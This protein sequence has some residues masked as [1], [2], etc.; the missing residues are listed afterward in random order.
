VTDE[1][2]ELSRN[3]DE[4]ELDEE[5]VP[6]LEGDSLAE[7]L[8]LRLGIPIEQVEAKKA[9]L[10]HTDARAPI[11]G[12]TN[13]TAIRAEIQSVLQRLSDGTLDPKV[14]RL[15]LYGFQCATAALPKATTQ[16]KP[17]R[18]KRGKK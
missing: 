18:R 10:K 17:Q 1:R 6:P 8:L 13:R 3:E 2:E 16:P 4:Y 12:L 11:K 9:S 14:A 15:M 7:T 5:E